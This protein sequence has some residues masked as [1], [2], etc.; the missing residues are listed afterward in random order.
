MCDERSLKVVPD[1]VNYGF[2][3]VLVYA[4]LSGDVAKLFLF[5]LIYMLFYSVMAVYFVWRK[6]KMGHSASPKQV[7]SE[8][9]S[10][11]CATTVVEDLP[12][13]EVPSRTERQEGKSD[14]SEG[15]MGL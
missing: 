6:K 7:P 15:R 4:F 9:D 2:I 12:S 13:N 11:H 5:F 3:P 14:S 8:R 1:W 10:P